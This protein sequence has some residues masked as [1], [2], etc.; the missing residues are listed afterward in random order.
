MNN[1]RRKALREAITH[2]EFA[3]DVVSDC[4]S[5]EREAFNNM[6][7]YIQMSEKGERMEEIADTLE[8]AIGLID[9][10]VNL[11]NEALE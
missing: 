8:E 1:Q 3:R 6:P 5:I 4:E 10:A 11:T 7:E 9:E 2:L